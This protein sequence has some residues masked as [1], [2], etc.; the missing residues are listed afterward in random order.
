MA[1][2]SAF[3]RRMVGLYALLVG[4]LA[5][6]APVPTRADSCVSSSLE[7]CFTNTDGNAT[8]L[9]KSGKTT[10]S[11]TGSKITS[12]GWET[13]GSLGTLSFT[14]G[15]LTSGTL[16]AGGTF[17]ATGSSFSV[18]NGSY[19]TVSDG[20]IFSGAF[21]GP[22]TWS[23]VGTCVTGSIC[24][25]DLAGN[26]VG[27]WNP[28]G[29]LHGVGGATVQLYFQTVGPYSGGTITDLGGVSYAETPLVTP[30]PGTLGLM[31]TGLVGLGLVVKSKL[32]PDGSTTQGKAVRMRT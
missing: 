18:L 24:T 25:Y 17:S 12:I 16:A 3:S 8:S 31:G 19:N 22:I 20:T 9:T 2:Q 10:F 30:E 4:L 29:P 32:R 13:G 26:I 28:N 11:L 23:V 1:F 14:T 15:D 7:T 6:L 21:V 27:T 5:F